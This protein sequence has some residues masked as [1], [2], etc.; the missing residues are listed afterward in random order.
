MQLERPGTFSSLGRSG[1]LVV[2]STDERYFTAELVCAPARAGTPDRGVDPVRVH[3]AG[4]RPAH[5]AAALSR[6]CPALG[7]LAQWGAAVVLDTG[8][9][10][11]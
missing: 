8:R 3:A 9:V 5:Q 7:W 10:C 2:S 4:R 6:W 11:A 1:A